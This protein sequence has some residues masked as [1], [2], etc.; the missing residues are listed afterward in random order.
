MRLHAII[1]T[2]NMQQYFNDKI[3]QSKEVC[4]GKNEKV[5]FSLGM[6]PERR[7]KASGCAHIL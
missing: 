4:C 1:Y 3:V 2:K 7:K 5:M 6:T